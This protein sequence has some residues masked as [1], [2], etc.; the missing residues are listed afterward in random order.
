MAGIIMVYSIISSYRGL[1]GETLFHNSFDRLYD[2]LGLRLYLYIDR[3]PGLQQG[4]VC[5]RQGFRNK[6]DRK[7]ILLPV[8]GCYGKAAAINSQKPF[9]EH[10]LQ[11]IRLAFKCEPFVI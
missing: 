4:K 6:V 9:F 8:E 5:S 2:N 10:K 11:P 3:V 1:P 7:L